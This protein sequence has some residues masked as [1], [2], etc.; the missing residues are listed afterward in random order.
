[1]QNFFIADG[2]DAATVR[3]VPAEARPHSNCFAVALVP[4]PRRESRPTIDKA[5]E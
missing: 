5:P 3:G 1:V 2:V 4:T